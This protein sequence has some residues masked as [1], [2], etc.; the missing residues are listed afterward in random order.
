MKMIILAQII[1]TII[2]HSNDTKIVEKYE[3]LEQ[4]FYEIAK[5]AFL[6]M[7]PK[8]FLF[9]I[10]DDPNINSNYKRYKKEFLKIRQKFGDLRFFPVFVKQ[11]SS[12]IIF[13]RFPRTQ[14]QTVKT[15]FLFKM[16]TIF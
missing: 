11:V 15:R 9:D 7:L 4:N 5:I 8:L 10:F 3:F 6:Y 2:K 12:S 1:N 16:I 14:H 13:I